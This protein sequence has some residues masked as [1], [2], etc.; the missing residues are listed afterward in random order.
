MLEIAVGGLAEPPAA[1]VRYSPCEGEPTGLGL[2]LTPEGQAVLAAIFLRHGHSL[3]IRHTAELAK[4]NAALCTLFRFADYSELQVGPGVWRYRAP[5][6]DP[7]P[8][9]LG[10][11]LAFR[12]ERDGVKGWAVELYSDEWP[13]H[14]DLLAWAKGLSGVVRIYTSAFDPHI[15]VADRAIA[16]AP[17]ISQEGLA[18]KKKA[19][20]GKLCKAEAAE[21]IEVSKELKELLSEVWESGGFIAVKYAQER[22]SADVIREA[23]AAGYL[24]LD[25]ATLTLKLT[26]AGM[27]LIE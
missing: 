6:V 20:G 26:E 1:E 18:L 16:A 14:T 15:V 12:L 10:L 4:C 27:A 21:P 3:L 11:A 13:R 19:E 5:L 25:S 7:V 23:I 22:Y 17:F 9:A 2:R 8:L 24:R